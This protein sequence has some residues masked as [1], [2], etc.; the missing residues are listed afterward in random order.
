M[1]P[2][3]AGLSR[4]AVLSAWNHALATGA[5]VRHTAVSSCTTASDGVT[6]VSRSPDALEFALRLVPSLSRKNAPQ[7][8]AKPTPGQCSGGNSLVDAVPPAVSAICPSTRPPGPRPNP[9]LPH[10]PSL[11]VADLPT[12]PA[13]N[14]PSHKVLLNKFPVDK[15]H[16][17]VVSSDFAPQTGLWDAADSRAFVSAL[18]TLSVAPACDMDINGAPVDNG[19]V[20]PGA[21]RL[22][23]AELAGEW[24]L[25]YNLGANSGASQAHRHAQLLPCWALGGYDRPQETPPAGFEWESSAVPISRVLERW[26]SQ[27]ATPPR[28]NHL[29]QLPEN[30]L[31]FLHLA[32]LLDPE[33][34]AT[35]SDGRAFTPNAVPGE[36]TPRAASTV[37]HLY[38]QALERLAS[39]TDTKLPPAGPVPAD[40]AHTLDSPGVLS[41]NILLTRRWLLVV[42]RQHPAV[43]LSFTENRDAV[44]A[45]TDLPPENDS[46]QGS[47]T[48]TFSM[49]A[50]GF[51]GAVLVRDT[52]ELALTLDAAALT[53][54]AIDLATLPLA[55]YPWQPLGSGE[56]AAQGG[57]I[58]VVTGL[59]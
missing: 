43:T 2:L 18:Q 38:L 15:G 29:F 23:L 28:T 21:A 56:P 12:A 4:M 24:I 35:S 11:F 53:H 8:P 30:R 36:W 41:A 52:Q 3:P 13:E 22:T 31:P 26:T 48:L 46:P 50:L 45:S 34:F 39:A 25:F 17:L 55:G 10:D 58:D 9:F 57:L 27:Q 6:R 16:V 20:D 7:A 59:V 47:P 33:D 32:A 51:A 37:H 54:G 42:P 49:N 1:S 40:C 5:L 19:S 14:P 44:I